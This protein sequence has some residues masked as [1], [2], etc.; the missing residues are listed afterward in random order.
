MT[1]NAKVKIWLTSEFSN[2]QF[3]H[4]HLGKQQQEFDSLKPSLLT[5]TYICGDIYRYLS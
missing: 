2:C 4:G 5:I 3:L 1:L